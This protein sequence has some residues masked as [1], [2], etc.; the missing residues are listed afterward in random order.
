MPQFVDTQ[1]HR[2]LKLGLRNETARYIKHVRSSDTARDHT[3]IKFRSRDDQDIPAN[4]AGNKPRKG[5][6]F[7]IPP[8]SK[9]TLNFLEHPWDSSFAQQGV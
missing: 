2:G 1:F 6:A 7:P 9:P 3:L 8:S 5:F 4:V